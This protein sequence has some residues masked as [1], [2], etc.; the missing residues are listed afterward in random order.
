MYMY[1]I[2]YYVFWKMADDLPIMALLSRVLTISLLPPYADIKLLG[3]ADGV[4][5]NLVSLTRR[6]G[7]V[8][9]AGG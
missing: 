6:C 4:T 2:L 7:Q 8:R 9:G 5:W 3:K 1:Q